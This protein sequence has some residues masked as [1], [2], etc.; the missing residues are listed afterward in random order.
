MQ[1]ITDNDIRECGPADELFAVEIDQIDV[2]LI[3]PFSVGQA[4]VKT[5]LLMLEG[6]TDGLQVCEQADQAFLLGH[7]VFD[8]LVADQECLN[9]GFGD[10]RHRGYS[11]GV[12][13]AVKRNCVSDAVRERREKEEKKGVRAV[14]GPIGGP[15]IR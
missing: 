1:A 13:S 15:L 6:E 10:I 8:D 7:A 12:W 2:E 5:H 4:E 3:G 11:T 14:S 9:A